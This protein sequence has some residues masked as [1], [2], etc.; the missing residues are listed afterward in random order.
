[1]QANALSVA[2][3]VV[4]L[5]PTW[6]GRFR[7]MI[8]GTSP[9]EVTFARRGFRAGE[10]DARRRLERVGACFLH[11][12][13][14][15]L[16]LNDPWDIASEL[17][18][19][20]QEDLGFA[21][22]GAAMAIAM[23]DHLLPWRIYNESEMAATMF[24]HFLPCLER[25]LSGF[26]NGPGAAHVYMVHVGVGWALAR[27][28]LRIEPTL[29]SLH[30]LL[31]WLV[32]DGYGF[33]EGYFHWRRSVRR[34]M[35]PSELTGYARR[36]FDQGVGRSLWFVDGAAV[37]LIEQTVRSFHR[38]RHADLWS[39]VGLA[40][41]YSGAA[42]S[43]SLA[44]LRDA[45]D[46]Y[47]PALAQG[48]AFAAKARQLAGIPADHTEAACEILCGMSANEAAAVT[49]A[50]LGDL[51]GAGPLPKYEVWRTAIQ[52]HFA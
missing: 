7:R 14:T 39:G 6:L 23:L 16:M 11:G 50:A 51:P 4:L 27:L 30:P 13:H 26:I 17:E 29:A 24:D 21:Y 41:T 9:R 28:R 47:G 48:A 10:P 43:Q 33:H 1:M 3:R 8:L 34:G 31:K 12:F 35:V 46:S 45:C 44:A 36:A 42:D 19:V 52:R 37:P 15:A 49:D 2:Q 5:R 25:R 22:E 38:D 32:I 20:E 18:A 40:A